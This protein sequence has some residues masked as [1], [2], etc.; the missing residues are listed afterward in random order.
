MGGCRR[1]GLSREGRC[2]WCQ[3]GR[4]LRP[5]LPGISCPPAFTWLPLL[6]GPLSWRLQSLLSQDYF[7]SDLRGMLGLDQ[8]SKLR[9]CWL[10]SCCFAVTQRGHAAL[11]WVSASWFCAPWL[12]G[13][14]VGKV[15]TLLH[16]VSDTA[17]LTP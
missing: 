13:V 1:P 2:V 5:V 4:G 14:G 3:R 8:I 17:R 6:L 15:V 7:S 12:A 16:M 10:L 11:R 9:T